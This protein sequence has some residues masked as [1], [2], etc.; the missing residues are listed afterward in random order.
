MVLME[1]HQVLTGRP[2]VLRRPIQHHY[3]LEVNR[4]EAPENDGD[5]IMDEDEN[6]QKS[7]V[8]ACRNCPKRA[9]ASR[10]RQNRYVDI[11]FPD[12]NSYL[13]LCIIELA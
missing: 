13:V 5:H 2:S 4:D 9:V 12:L 3:P 6:G 11:K 1:K 8:S 10:A 7:V